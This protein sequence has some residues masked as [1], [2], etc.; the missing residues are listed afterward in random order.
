[1]IAVRGLEKR[2]VERGKRG[3]KTFL[4]TFQESWKTW[5]IGSMF[6]QKLREKL[7]HFKQRKDIKRFILF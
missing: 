4:K 3:T 6:S 7:K 2:K 5:R 1:M